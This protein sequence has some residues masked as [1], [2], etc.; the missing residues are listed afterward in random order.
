MV[1]VAL[2]RGINVGGNNKVEMSKLKTTFETLG[3]TN[4]RSYINS[5]NIIFTSA[6]ESSQLVSEIEDAIEFDFG[7]RVHV[8]LRDK[9]NINAVVKA[10]PTSWV[11]DVTMKTDVMFLW[12]DVDN[13]GVLGAL[14][15]KPGIDDVK[16]LPG[17]VVWRVDKANVNR[18]GLLRIVSTNL[19]KKITIRNVNTLRKLD[20]LMNPSY[21]SLV[22]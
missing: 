12:D 7:F 21:D 8:V 20:K 1:Y 16:Y 22:K 6:K 2:L 10:V 14:T 4:V 11:N 18:S 15:I 9:S 17:A 13:A 19:Y 5:G 3:H